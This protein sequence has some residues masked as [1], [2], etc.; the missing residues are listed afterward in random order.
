MCALRFPWFILLVGFGPVCRR[1]EGGGDY[2]WFLWGLAVFVGLGDGSFLG[3]CVCVGGG[4]GGGEG[5]IGACGL[6]PMSR[7]RCMC[8]PRLPRFIL[9]VNFSDTLL[10]VSILDMIAI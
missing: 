8:A 4:G 9:Q 3:V 7:A 6:C 1:W 2:W 5:W 10:M